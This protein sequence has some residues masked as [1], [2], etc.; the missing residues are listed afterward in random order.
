M[1]KEPAVG[2]KRKGWNVRMV[3]PDLRSLPRFDLPEG[4][5]L[6]RYVQG[7]EKAWLD[8]HRRSDWLS[9]HDDESFRRQFGRDEAMLADRQYYLVCPD[10]EPIGTATAWFDND[11]AGLSWGRLHWVA[12]VPEFQGRGLAKPL[13]AA[14]CERMATLGHERALLDTNTERVAAIGLYLRFGFV[15]DIRHE[16]DVTAW[17]LMRDRLPDGPLAERSFKAP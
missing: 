1:S 9:R 5:A 16:Q 6:R 12:I 2:E 3:R 10:G 15:P 8:I 11:Y 13:V 7:D 14:A 4:F 17:R